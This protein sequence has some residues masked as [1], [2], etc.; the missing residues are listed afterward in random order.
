MKKANTTHN[1]F[2]ASDFQLGEVVFELSPAQCA[3]LTGGSA[4][5]ETLA[6]NGR[7]PRD[8]FSPI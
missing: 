4:M 3:Q 1:S 8:E 7:R 6:E 5:I 2:S